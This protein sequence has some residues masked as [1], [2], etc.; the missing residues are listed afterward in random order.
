MLTPQEFT[1]R[2]VGLPWERWRSDWQACDCW[3]LLSMACREVLGFEIGAEPSGS[4]SPA[5]VVGMGW[6]E[7]A[8]DSGQI[9]LM[10][11]IDGAPTHCAFVT[12]G[13]AT[14]LHSAANRQGIGQVQETRISVMRRLYPDIRIY[15]R[16]AR[17]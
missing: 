8:E 15:R 9:A 5:D 1:A 12:N 3:G 11:W 4:V 6:L 2:A 14:L 10:G 17:C 16:A 13:G 7:C